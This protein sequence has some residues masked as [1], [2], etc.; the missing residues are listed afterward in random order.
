MKKTSRILFAIVACIMPIF[1]GALHTFVHF[2]DLVKPDVQD[3]LLKEFVYSGTAQPL[4]N[5][6]GIMSFMMGMSFIIIGMLNVSVLNRTPKTNS[7]PLLPVLSMVLYQLCVIYVGSVFNGV[8]Q[9]YGGIFG[10]LL[11]TI[12]LFT[13]LKND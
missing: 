1:I 6:W 13:T 11:I 12:C 5:A 8:F 2:T 10:L 9:F 3:Y 7:L 4:W